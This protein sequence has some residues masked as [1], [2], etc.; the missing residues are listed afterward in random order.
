MMIESND[1]IHPHVGHRLGHLC[2]LRLRHKPRQIYRWYSK[3]FSGLATSASA[4]P[5]SHSE[6]NAKGDALLLANEKFLEF[7]ILIFNVFNTVFINI[8]NPELI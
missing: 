4:F 8:G 1:I 6:D 2:L 3:E 5:S 7:D